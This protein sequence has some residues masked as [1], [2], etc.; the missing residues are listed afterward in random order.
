MVDVVGTIKSVKD[1]IDG[2]LTQMQA[3]ANLHELTLT[4]MPVYAQAISGLEKTIDILRS[5]FV[6]EIPNQH[7]V[8]FSQLS[9][10]ELELSVFKKTLDKCVDWHKSM[11]YLGMLPSSGVHAE[12][13]VVVDVDS[14]S[15]FRTKWAHMRRVF[16]VTPALLEQEVDRA[17]QQ[18]L[19]L[20]QD[21]VVLQ[22]DILGSAVE[23][24]HPVLRRAW[25]FA[26]GENQLNDSSLSDLA[27]TESLYVLLK[28]EEGGVIVREAFCKDVIANFVRYLDGLAGTA[29]DKMIS[30]AEIKQFSVTDENSKNVKGLLGLKQQPSEEERVVPV[31]LDWS[32]VRVVNTEKVLIPLC[33]GYGCN[34]PSKVAATFVVPFLSEEEEE[35]EEKKKK[36]LVGVT[37]RCF[38][39]DQGFGGTGH[40][41]VRFQV[42]DDMPVPAFSVWRDKILDG[43]YSFVIGPDKVR[44]GDKVKIWA[45][46][47]PWN[48]WSLCVSDVAAEAKFA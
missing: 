22:R 24:Q 19:P 14:C 44:A 21:V 37:V 11:V 26:R 38:A 18:I 13:V 7:L 39:A 41:Q 20:L 9:L 28:Q 17:F 6:S 27:L 2:A 5:V 31:A 35:E 46:S 1:C 23:I 45:C 32:S 42:N 40:A 10:L 43:K 12:S 4:K 34:W 48:A 36:G 8:R 16:R 3:L 33:E 25:M 29:P 15:G 30:L 47:P